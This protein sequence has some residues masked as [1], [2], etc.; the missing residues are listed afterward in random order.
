MTLAV[1]V[2]VTPWLLGSEVVTE[3]QALF[4][5]KPSTQPVP[6]VLE[7]VPEAVMLQCVLA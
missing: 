4:I 2:S 5:T 6:R 7:A 1:C 3:L